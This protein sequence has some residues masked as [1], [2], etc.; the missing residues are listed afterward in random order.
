MNFEELK[1]F[2]SENYSIGYY[3]NPSPS[4][5]ESIFEK[6]LILIS[7]INYI[8]YKTKL[9]HPSTTYYEIIV[10]LSKNLGI[11]DSFKQGLAIV[12]EDLAYGCDGDFPTFGLKGNDIVKKAVD[13]LKT[14]VPF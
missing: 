14:Y 12:C 11:P 9:K 1:K 3:L 8:T 4:E 13:I 7:L 10:K 5:G 6:K 2:Y